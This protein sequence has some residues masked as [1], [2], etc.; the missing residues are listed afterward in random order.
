MMILVFGTTG[1]VARSLADLQG[2]REIIFLGRNVVDLTAPEICAELILS[3]R[4]SV[5]LNAAAYTAVDL[6][7][8]EETLAR[9]VN[10][11]A[12]GTMAAACTDLGVPFCHVSTDYVFSGSGVNPYKTHDTTD[13]QNAYGRT[14]LAGEDAVRAAG[15]QYAILRTS[16]VFSEYGGNFVKT[17]LRLSE[18][19]NALNVV[20]DQIGGP[21]PARGIAEALLT[22][23]DALRDGQ[24]GGTYHYTGTPDVS[25]AAFARGIFDRAGRDITV[26]GIPTTDYPTPA[27][28]PL[29]SRLDCSAILADFGIKQPSWQAELDRILKDL[30]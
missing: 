11:V 25:W 22:V 19:R 10:A 15:G 8:E 9:T 24:T 3:K 1:Q 16:W 7:E 29:N 13:P 17:M 4:P 30:T 6:A 12:P 2:D 5:V 21:T 23:A 28:R 14:K 26:T 18:T 20:D 27:R